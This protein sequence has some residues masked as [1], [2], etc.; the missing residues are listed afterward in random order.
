VIL[1]MPK[2]GMEM[3][4]GVVAGWLADDGQAVSAGDPVYV[5]ETDKVEH[6]VEAPADGVLRQ[7]VATGTT[8]AVGEPVA[9]LA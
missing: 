2:L 4:E 3:S 1:R 5:I 7:L 6:E 8:V 9:E